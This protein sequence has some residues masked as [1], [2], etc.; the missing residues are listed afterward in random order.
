MLMLIYHSKLWFW[1]IFALLVQACSSSND[2]TQKP[3]I[4][5]KVNPHALADSMKMEDTSN[6]KVFQLNETK[7]RLVIQ[8]YFEKYNQHDFQALKDF[9]ANEVAQ[10]IQMK[11]IKREVVSKTAQNFFKDKDKIAFTPDLSQLHIAEK[12]KK[13]VT[14]EFPL[15]MAWQYEKEPTPQELGEGIKQVIYT[16]GAQVFLSLTFDTDYKITSYVE[17]DVIVEKYITKSETEAQNANNPEDKINL[18]E[19]TILTDALE[20]RTIVKELETGEQTLFQRKVK[21]KDNFYW[22]TDG[23]KEAGHSNQNLY[24]EKVEKD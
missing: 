5:N 4:N 19:G 16:Y 21:Y 2:T 24:L 7:L 18:K 11:N 17:K 3:K 13:G 14:V 6:E 9:Y 22:I 20:S 15:A 8:A 23:V 10:F 1:I 12:T